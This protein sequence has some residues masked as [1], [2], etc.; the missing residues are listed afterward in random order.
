MKV[1]VSNFLSKSISIIDKKLLIEEDRIDLYENVYPH[2][3]CIDKKE[4]IIYIPSSLNGV[5][6]IVSIKDKVVI[7]SVSIGGNLSQ[8]ALYN[9][10]ELYIAN[11]DS[12][13]IYIIDI[14]KMNPIGV[15]CVDDM[16]HGMV[17]D[18]NQHKLYVPCSDYFTVIDVISKNIVEKVK[19]NFMPWHLKVD[20]IK[21]VIYVATKDGHIVLLDRFTFKTIKTLNN[22]KLPIEIAFNNLKNEVYVTDFC[23]KSIDIL[24][25]KKYKIIKKIEILGRPLGISISNDKKLLFVS[26]I[27]NNVIK[28]FNTE[29]YNFIKDIK[30]DKEPTTI[31]CR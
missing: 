6:Y 21:N 1:Y 13:S 30:V 5:L 3:F 23:N 27:E 28:V 25:S 22:F 18:K 12:N 14:Q 4:E 2:H 31:I 19:L 7:D 15:I 9:D 11:E 26:D 10:E 17:L 8:V 20:E 16:P 24:D 29:N